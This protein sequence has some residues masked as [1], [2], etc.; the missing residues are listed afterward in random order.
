MTFSETK[1]IPKHENDT[2][3][4]YECRRPLVDEEIHA[5]RTNSKPSISERRLLRFRRAALSF[6]FDFNAF[7]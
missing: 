1:D 6:G 5:A 4:A 7:S 3:D 2:D